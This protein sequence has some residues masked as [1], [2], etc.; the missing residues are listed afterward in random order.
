MAILLDRGP[1]CFRG[2]G[3]ATRCASLLGCAVTPSAFT[4]T[5]KSCK[6]TEH[7]IIGPFFGFECPDQTGW[8]ERARQAPCRARFSVPTADVLPTHSLKSGRRTKLACMTRTSGQ[9]YRTRGFPLASYDADRWQGNYEFETMMREIS[10]SAKSS[11]LEK[12]AVVRRPAVSISEFRNRCT[13]RSPRNS[14]KDDAHMAKDPLG[15][16]KPSMAIELKQEGKFLR[17]HLDIVLQ[18]LLG[19]HL[20]TGNTAS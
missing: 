16:R 19:A 15:R 5:A 4:A 3:P 10:N 17:G 20:R 6:L 8:T 18:R 12:Y 14:F 13:S 2:G 1:I 11:G 7:E 9:L